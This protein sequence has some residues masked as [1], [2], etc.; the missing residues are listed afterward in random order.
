MAPDDV[1]PLFR[2]AWYVDPNAQ[3]IENRLQMKRPAVEGQFV[4]FLL[5]QG[6]PQAVTDA[7][8]ASAANQQQSRALETLLGA[9]DWLL[10]TQASR[11]GLGAVERPGATD[12][13]PHRWGRTPP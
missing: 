2:L 1:T 8:L 13:L 7:A 4:N 3:E 10:A 6:D 11:S 5:T 12:M 9:C